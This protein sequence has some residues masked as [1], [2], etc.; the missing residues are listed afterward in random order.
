ML[1][2]KIKTNFDDN[3]HLKGYRF[4]KAG[5]IE[6]KD[7]QQDLGWIRCLYKKDLI[8]DNNILFPDLRR[9]EDPVFFV[10]AMIAAKEFYAIP[11]VVYRYRI[12]HKPADISQ[13]VFI[14]S[15]FGIVENLKISRKYKYD[16]L[17]RWTME[18][19]WFNCSLTSELRKS[20]RER[21]QLLES[22]GNLHKDIKKLNREKDNLRDET[23]SVKESRYYKIGLAITWIPRRIKLMSKKILKK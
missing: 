4:D 16:T 14:D 10:E 3:P 20:D 6:Y 18:S 1:D 23:K 21:Q 15:L 9:H 12:F 11:D 5:K 13:E 17:E 2:G 19:F 7:W 22:I 8:I